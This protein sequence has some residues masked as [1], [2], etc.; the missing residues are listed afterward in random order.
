MIFFDLDDTLM[1]H[2]GA[3]R[4]G[5]TNVFNTFRS[6]FKDD[7]ASFLIRWHNVSEKYFQ[8]NSK[9]KYGLWEERCLRMRELFSEEFSDEEAESRFEKYLS[10][11]EA[12]WQLYPDCIPCLNKLQGEKMGL[13]SNGEGEMQRS[14]IQ[15]LG[16][17]SY[18]STVIISREV[19]CAKPD[20]AIFELAAKQAGVDIKECTYIGD[21]LQADAISSQQAGMKGIWLN[22]KAKEQDQDLGV[23]IIRSLMELPSLFQH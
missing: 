4:A 5:A 16:L 23:P 8:S 12:N 3:A 21:R 18:F 15:K 22:R 9:I 19:D 2:E 20:K 7:L 1:D 6:C 10:A 14:K 13:I 17:G 11:Y